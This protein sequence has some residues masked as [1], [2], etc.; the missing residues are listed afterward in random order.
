MSEVVEEESG[1]TPC[2]PTS[3]WLTPNAPPPKTNALASKVPGSK[4]S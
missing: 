3:R 2:R 4:K 1:G